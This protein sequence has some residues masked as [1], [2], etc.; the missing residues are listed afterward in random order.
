MASQLV[1]EVNAKDLAARIG[2]L[3]INGKT[4]ETPTLMPV[5]NPRKEVLSPRELHDEFDIQLLM[6]NAYILLR[7]DELKNKALDK[8]I[9]KLLDFDGIIATDSG[10]Y[11]LMQ[12]GNVLT[13]NEQII[14]FQN[15][16][17][18]DIGSF[19]DIPS[20][21]DAF[22]ARA[23]EQLNLTLARAK[24]AKEKASFIVNAGIQGSTHLDLRSEAARALGG[25][26]SLCAV[27][28]IVGIMEQYRFTELVDIIAA[29]KKNIPVDRVVHA[30]G[31]G[32]PMVF[33]LAVALGCDL[34]DSAA[35]VLYA[36]EGRY[37]TSTG[38]LH[39]DNL[40]YLPCSC[41]VCSEYGMDLKQLD[42][43]D[44]TRALARHNLYV[45]F[46]ELA[47]V[48]QA[49]YEGSLMNMLSR[50]LR[51]HPQLFSGLGALMKH[52]KWL[53][54]LDR[55]T[56][57]APFYYLGSEAHQRTE[58]LNVKQRL[59]RVKSERT[60]RMP[61]FGDVPLE[62]TSMYPFVSYMAPT[63]VKIDEVYARIRDI[64]RIR[65]MMDYQFVPGAGDLIPKKARIKKSRKTGRMR[66]VY[67]GD[68]LIASLRASDNWIIP[69]TKLIKGLHELIPNPLL[70]VVIDDEAKP[71]V[72][73]GK[74]VFC[75]F[76]LE[77]D[78]NLRCMDEVLVVDVNDELIRGGT[79]HLSPREVRDFS[80]GMAVRVR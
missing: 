58:V 54:E 53:S 1:F 44:K 30:F 52:N 11:Q 34:F 18:S 9:H 46:M 35:Y 14:E 31:L 26:F 10:S 7:N 73:E 23:R 67:E 59:K 65:A 61:P 22:K 80:K 2:K 71:F 36:K 8:G 43:P 25:D 57:K 33:S 39:L 45:S 29:V 24:E 75:K 79:L 78:D 76:V 6:T 32:H 49:I 51:S 12:Y 68:E 64:D 17:G 15:S 48:K 28:G 60:I 70:R 5:V 42:E 72:S 50:R 69:K 38:T 56:R 16:I 19:L 21:P 77:I 13:S 27:G 62:L 63:S 40:H 55:I 47:R 37:L 4:I 20:M 3:E 41:P 66:W 74:S